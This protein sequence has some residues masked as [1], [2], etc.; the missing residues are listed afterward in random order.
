MWCQREVDRPEHRGQPVGHLGR[1]AR[2]ERGRDVARAARRTSGR[3]GAAPTR[4][5]HPWCRAPAARRARPA[6]AASPARSAARRAGS[7]GAHPCVSPSADAAPDAPRRQR[8]R[9]A[10]GRAAGRVRPCG[11]ERDSPQAPAGTRTRARPLAAA[12]L[13][14]CRLDLEHDAA[15]LADRRDL[16]DRPRHPGRDPRPRRRPRAA[17]AQPGQQGQ[18]GQQGSPARASGRAGRAA[19]RRRPATTPYHQGVAAARGDVLPDGAVLAE[20]WRRLVGPH[21]RPRR[22][23][24]VDGDRGAAR[25]SARRCRRM[26]DYVDRSPG[27]RGVGWDASPSRRRSRWSSARRILPGD[28]DLGIVGGAR[29]RDGL[30]H[31]AV[32]RPPGRCCSAPSCAGSAARAGSTW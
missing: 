21:P 11:H 31:H 19:G 23:R 20:W 30:P 26:S 27:G 4:A 15:P 9:R 13:R 32:V 24:G 8:R 17:W 3:S 14:R 5:R 18:S 12:V 28:P 1:R 22:H 25:G 7:S 16:H 10:T 29:L 6:P 2:H